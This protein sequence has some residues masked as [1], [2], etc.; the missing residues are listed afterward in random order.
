MFRFCSWKHDFSSCKPSLKE[1]P[2]FINIR[3]YFDCGSLFCGC[4]QKHLPP[5]NARFCQQGIAMCTNKD[6]PPPVLCILEIRSASC[7][8]IPA[9]NESSGSSNKSTDSFS[10]RP[11]IALE[12][13]VSRQ[14][15]DLRVANWY[16][17]ASGNNVLVSEGDQ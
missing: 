10:R 1:S 16:A 6:L 12:D 13:E 11:I 2:H 7:D 17:D 4:K 3:G 8:T 5:V 14:K 15:I 9:F